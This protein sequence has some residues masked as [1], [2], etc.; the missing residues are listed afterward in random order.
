MIIA[1]LAAGIAV[2][3]AHGLPLRLNILA[4]AAVGISAGLLVERRTR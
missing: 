2:I 3:A 4:A 1:A